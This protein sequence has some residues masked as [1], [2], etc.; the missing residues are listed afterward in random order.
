M[1]EFIFTNSIRG[2]FKLNF[3][4]RLNLFV[5]IKN[6]SSLISGIILDVGCGKK[7]YESLF[8]NKKEYIGID[9]QISGHNH[10]D[11]KVDTWFD[12]INIPYPDSH[13]DN[14]VCFE[15]LEHAE[16]PYKLVAEMFRVLKKDG[17][18]LVTCP[19]IYPEHE[20]PYDFKRFTLSGLIKLFEMSSFKVLHATKSTSY[21]STLIQLYILHVMTSKISRR[22]PTH[23][24]LKLFLVF[25]LNLISLIS[26]KKNNSETILYLNTILVLKK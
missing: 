26:N 22:R 25:P 8:T 4:T 5:N 21:F 6:H 19:F 24:L 11:S 15:V 18:I 2:L 10:F 14:I 23:F 13:F 3:I 16:Q 12:G 20:M 17:H 7:P 9:V 1:S